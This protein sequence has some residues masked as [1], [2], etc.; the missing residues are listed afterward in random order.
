MANINTNTAVKLFVGVVL[1][2]AGTVVCNDALKQVGKK[3][4][5][6]D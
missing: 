6:L 2:T 3:L 5:K 1:L 4:L